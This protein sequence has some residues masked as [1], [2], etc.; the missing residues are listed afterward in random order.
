M[1]IKE[2]MVQISCRNKT[3]YKTKKSQ[4]TKNYKKLEKNLEYSSEIF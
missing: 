1:I 3:N 4:V 2:V